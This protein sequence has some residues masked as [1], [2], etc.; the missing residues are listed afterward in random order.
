MCPACM[1]V[2]AAVAFGTASAGGLA[3]LL[4]PNLLRK[5]RRKSGDRP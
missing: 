5:T 1:S 2:A 3:G 4:L